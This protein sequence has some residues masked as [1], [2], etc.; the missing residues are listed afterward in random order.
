[1]QIFF[2]THRYTPFPF[3]CSDRDY[4]NCIKVFNDEAT[5]TTI[6]IGLNAVHPDAPEKP[7]VVRA[8]IHV[9]AMICRVDEKDPNST[10]FTMI[11]H[12]D[13]KGLLPTFVVNSAIIGSAD[14]MRAEMTKYYHETYLKEKKAE[15]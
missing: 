6:A 11:T 13:M 14:K 9:N 1:M 5:N 8:Q 4:V 10:V 12:T 7:K 2:A 3:P 15:Q